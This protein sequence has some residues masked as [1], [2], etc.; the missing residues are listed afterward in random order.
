MDKQHA[1]G[2]PLVAGLLL[3]G[4][5]A[6][7]PIGPSVMAL[8]G[9]GKTFDQFRADDY[10]CRQ[11]STQQI[12]GTPDQ[13]ATD[14]AVR[15]AAIGTLIGAAAGAA[16][17]GHNGAGVGAGTGLLVGSM[18]GANAA[19]ASSYGAQRRYD[20]FYVQCMY[21]HGHR[22]PVAGRLMSDPDRV[23]MPTGPTPA[24]SIPPPPPGYPPPPPPG[25]PR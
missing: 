10:V 16:I 23:S 17:G 6:V 7:A 20:Q 4:G 21:A 22:V 12:G 3:L 5:C 14:S 8:P 13:M 25:A 18:A 19:D 15:S 11:Y 1:F 9:S 24:A 2:L